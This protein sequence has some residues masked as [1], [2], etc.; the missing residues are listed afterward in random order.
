MWSYLKGDMSLDLNT[1][2]GIKAAKPWSS[3]IKLGS[4]A[5]R[6]TVVHDLFERDSVAFG[7]FKLMY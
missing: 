5:L 2:R 6:V 3:C 4:S 1:P 7:S